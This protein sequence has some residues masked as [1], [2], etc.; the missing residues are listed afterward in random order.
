MQDFFHQPYGSQKP[1]SKRPLEKNGFPKEKEPLPSLSQHFSGFFC[2]SFK[3]GAMVA[4]Q[5]TQ[6]ELFQLFCFGKMGKSWLPNINRNEKSGKNVSEIIPDG[7][8]AFSTI[9]E[10]VG[11]MGVSYVISL[12]V[13]FFWPLGPERFRKATPPRK[14][15]FPLKK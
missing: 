1:S 11:F 2:C 10:M 3:R 8:T 9:F 15:T 13:V 7:P 5:I 6:L 12:K 14:F 4:E